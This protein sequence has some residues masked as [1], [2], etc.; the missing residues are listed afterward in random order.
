MWMLSLAAD[1]TAGNWRLAAPNLPF[2]IC[3]WAADFEKNGFITCFVVNCAVGFRHP[4][5]SGRSMCAP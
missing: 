2:T 3:P 1:K 5:R 4:K